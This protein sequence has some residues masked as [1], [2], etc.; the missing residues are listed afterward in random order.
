MIPG[1][2]NHMVDA[3]D[4]EFSNTVLICNRLGCTNE[5]E[6]EEELCRSCQEEVCDHCGHTPETG[7]CYYCKMD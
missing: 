4:K 5:V 2:G 1:N 6:D 7:A 3:Q